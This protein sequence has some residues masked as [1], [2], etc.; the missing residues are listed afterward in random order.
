MI[1]LQEQSDYQVLMDLKIIHSNAKD[2]YPYFTLL[3]TASKRIFEKK[4]INR[5]T[6]IIYQFSHEEADSVM[7]TQ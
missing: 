6:S 2:V 3:I 1:K 7:P 5:E 4:K